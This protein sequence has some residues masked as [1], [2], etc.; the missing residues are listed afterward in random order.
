MMNDKIGTMS[1][2]LVWIFALGALVIGLA[3]GYATAG[4]GAK[5]SSAVFFFAFA[6][7]GFGATLL[8]RAKTWLAAVAF[9]LASLVA[10]GAYYGI[11]SSMISSS[12]SAGTDAGLFG[13]FLGAFVALITLIVSLI[14][15]V[16]GCVAGARAKSMMQQ[17]AQ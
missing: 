6:A 9:V 13:A 11:A 16:G 10:A 15:G 4:L 1:S 2:G 3:G 17:A 7:T 12:A 14:A 5:V 8:T